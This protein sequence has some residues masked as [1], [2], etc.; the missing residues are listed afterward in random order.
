M[1]KL[2]G[3]QDYNVLLTGAATVLKPNGDPLC[4]YLPGYLSQD[5]RDQA[6]PI[7]TTIRNV[8]VNRGQAGGAIRVRK[9]TKT[10]YARPLMSSIVGA[11]DPAP[12][13]PV[14]RLTAWTAEHLGQY[15][16]LHPF[17]QS[18]AGAFQQHVPDR[19]RNQMARV[20]RTQPEWIIPDTPYTTM[21]VNNTYATGVHKDA[22]D[23]KEGFSCLAVLRRGD[24]SGGQL[25]FPEFRV[26]VDL[27]DG[28][29]ILMD[30]H[31]WHGNVDLGSTVWERIRLARS[32]ALPHHYLGELNGWEGTEANRKKVYKDRG[33][34]AVRVR[35]ENSDAG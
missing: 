26:A 7:L 30:A 28:D 12:R 1:G 16:Q 4:I 10:T 13:H 21:T 34:V 24:Y 11:I 32:H 18:V 22:G 29:V 14:C 25:V 35:E 3:S 2:L 6:Y 15:R 27:Q 9:G 31:E 5:L 23:L 17:I 19:F 8:T 33:L 20:H